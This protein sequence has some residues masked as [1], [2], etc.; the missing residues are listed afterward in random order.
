MKFSSYKCQSDLETP[1][2]D[3]FVGPNCISL[4][5]VFFP[6]YNCLPGRFLSFPHKEMINPFINHDEPFPYLGTLKKTVPPAPRYEI[7][8]ISW[9]FIHKIGVSE[10]PAH[11]HGPHGHGPHGH[12]MPLTLSSASEEGPLPIN[13]LILLH[14]DLDVLSCQ[15]FNNASLSKIVFVYK[16]Y[17]YFC[18]SR[19]LQAKII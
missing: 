12:P 4:S 6:I 10:R 11:G 1:S 8:N 16:R 18:A 14:S 17:A 3:L 19:L 7:K 13:F 15:F 9:S 5:K 2:L